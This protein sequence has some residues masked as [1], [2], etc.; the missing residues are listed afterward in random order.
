MI[1]F[2]WRLHWQFP[3]QDEQRY[4]VQEAIR[5]IP[6][7]RKADIEQLRDKLNIELLIGKEDER[8]IR[9]KFGCGIEFIS[10]VPPEIIQRFLVDEVTK[11][12][13]EMR[14]AE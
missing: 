11:T 12:I 3:L 9:A 4:I 10:D 1:E 7:V 2:I 8:P 13:E 14:M 6:D 5:A